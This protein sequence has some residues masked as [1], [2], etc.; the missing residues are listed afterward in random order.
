MFSSA[1]WAELIS[2]VLHEPALEAEYICSMDGGCSLVDAG[3]LQFKIASNALSPL[4]PVPYKATPIILNNAS[5]KWKGREEGQVR[6]VWRELGSKS[7]KGKCE[8]HDGENTCVVAGTA[9]AEDIHPSA[10]QSAAGLL[11][12]GLSYYE[13]AASQTR[14]VF[15]SD[16]H[17]SFGPH[18]QPFL[19]LPNPG[20]QTGP[21]PLPFCS[22]INTLVSSLPT[23]HSSHL[24]LR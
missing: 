12:S 2:D 4:Q 23:P 15:P 19:Q 9:D 13:R 21:T 17:T 10:A 7:N 24:L 16:F 8:G 3:I 22:L 14:L 20:V 5:R 11:T 1:L 6:G 18:I